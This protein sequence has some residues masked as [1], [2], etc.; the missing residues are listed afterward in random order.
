MTGERLKTESGENQWEKT[1]FDAYDPE[2]AKQKREAD[3]Q[4]EIPTNPADQTA[5]ELQ[6]KPEQQDQQASELL[7]RDTIEAWQ[8]MEGRNF[9]PNQLPE[10]RKL[11]DKAESVTPI[12]ESYDDKFDYHQIDTR[13]DLICQEAAYNRASS[14]RDIKDPTA[15]HFKDFYLKSTQHANREKIPFFEALK[16]ELRTYPYK[17]E[18]DFMPV[19]AMNN[20]VDT[21]VAYQASKEPNLEVGLAKGLLLRR[22]MVLETAVHPMG[23]NPAADGI[24]VDNML[25]KPY[26]ADFVQA[27]SESKAPE[28]LEDFLQQKVVELE[29]SARMAKRHGGTVDPFGLNKIEAI[30]RSLREIKDLRETYADDLE[31][32]Q[33]AELVQG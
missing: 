23:G 2:L 29:S 31:E 4:A 14:M 12:L 25:L 6:A 13:R 27:N 8:R 15:R 30:N 16:S 17:D 5:E 18:D 28:K 1:E 22:E 33:N 19:D 10:L 26:L 9:D 21:F 24:L 11:F 32:I 20:Y 7:C 3:R